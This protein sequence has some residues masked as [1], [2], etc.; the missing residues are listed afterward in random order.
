MNALPVAI[1]G[2]D[3]L[4]KLWSLESSNLDG[5]EHLNYLMV[6]DF[7]DDNDYED[8]VEQRWE[9]FWKEHLL[10]EDGTVDLEQVKKELSDFY[11]LIHNIP[12]IYSEVTGGM[13]SKHLTDPSAVIQ[14]HRNYIEDLCEDHAKE[15][16]E[17]LYDEF[18][19]FLRWL[20]KS[21]KRLL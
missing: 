20:A 6:E 19:G 18:L 21:G 1:G 10:R 4:G 14:Q 3:G 8:V 11:V 2:E 17:D 9:H 13:V 12:S 5:E 15:V 16:T 7:I